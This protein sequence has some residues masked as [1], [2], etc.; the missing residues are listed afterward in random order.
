MST[1]FLNN[2]SITLLKVLTDGQIHTTHKLTSQFN[3][4]NE[5]LLN[6]IKALAHHGIQIKYI[7]NIGYYCINPI[8]WLD[9][10]AITKYLKKHLQ[11]FDVQIIDIIDS[12]NEYLLTNR[13]SFCNNNTCI[14]VIV[15]ELQ[16]KGRG[17]QSKFWYSCL[18]GGLTFSTIWTFKKNSSFSSG[19][20]LAIGLSVVRVF[21]SLNLNDILLKWPNDILW[22]KKKIA[23]ILI[24]CRS[25]KD[26]SIA[27]VIGIG[28][29]FR[30]LPDL[31][32]LINNAVTDLYS[33]CH[34]LLDR[35]HFI[36]LV[37][38][39]LRNIL[40]QYE[41][42]GFSFFREEWQQYHAF[43]G[44]KVVLKT[45][46]NEQIEGIVDGIEEDG[47]LRLLTDSGHCLC[48]VGEIS[49]RPAT[50]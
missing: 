7:S 23:G 42:Y 3:C 37:L 15:A 12:T 32:P 25:N 24:E 41:L 39:E 40:S 47:Q 26:G 16:T 1:Q 46:Y 6:V 22:N 31:I 50:Y 48:S 36:A 30:L 35:N 34:K 27:A 14:P 38:I 9:K 21:K 45:P 29:N 28:I 49:L 8:V 10:Y 13:Y 2:H 20:T 4:D 33:I 17:R 5:S 19:L 11:F 18:G 43:H 44:E